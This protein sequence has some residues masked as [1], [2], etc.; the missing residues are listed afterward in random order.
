VGT[1]AKGFISIFPLNN[2]KSQSEG[3][4]TNKAKQTIVYLT[5]LKNGACGTSFSM[6]RPSLENDV[7]VAGDAYGRSSEDS[8]YGSET[9]FLIQTPAK[10]APA[11]SWWPLFSLLSR[12]QRLF[13][14]IP[15]IISSVFAGGI[16]P[17]MTIVIGHAF[18]A[19]SKF[20][21][22]P[23]SS[24]GDPKELLL[25]RVGTAALQLI[26]L[27]IGSFMLSSLT[28]YLWILTGEHNI[29]EL[30]KRVYA[31]IAARDM[32]WFDTRVSEEQGVAQS[33]DEEQ[34]PLGAG[35]LMAQFTRCVVYP[36]FN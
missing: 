31:S 30:R 21:A 36:P 16:A 34:G 9:D 19:F 20:S 2:G 24:G 27:A 23:T 5:K 35:G 4:R 29:L 25:R 7:D 3:S 17:F 10:A 22:P 11:A 15:A 8:E 14:L 13:L 18:D 6:S 12:H 32:M 1:I 33:S 28:S 26:G